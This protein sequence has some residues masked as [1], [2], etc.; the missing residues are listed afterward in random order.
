MITE[1]QDEESKVDSYTFE[2]RI[3]KL[4]ER[5]KRICLF[6]G[7][8]LSYCTAFLRHLANGNFESAED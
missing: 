4:H 6:Y 3:A 5:F 1:R 2:T 8:P 7:L